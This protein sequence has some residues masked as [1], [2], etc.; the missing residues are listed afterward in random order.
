M[1]NH[2]CWGGPIL[3]H[4]QVGG[5]FCSQKWLADMNP[6]LNDVP[7]GPLFNSCEEDIASTKT[8]WE[9]GGGNQ[10]FCVRSAATV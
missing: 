10:Q 8:G 5:I 4:T 2:L 1:E 6:H 7:E 9:G 3:T